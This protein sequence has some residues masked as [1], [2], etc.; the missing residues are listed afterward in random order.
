MD[1]FFLTKEAPSYFLYYKMIYVYMY[2]AE[3]PRKRREK[4]KDYSTK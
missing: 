3:G 1:I 4:V 2:K